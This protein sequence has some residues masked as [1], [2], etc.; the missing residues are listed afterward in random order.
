VDWNQALAL[1]TLQSAANTYPELTLDDLTQLLDA[2]AAY[3]TWTAGT[4]YAYG[5]TV[6]PTVSNGHV[7]R[8]IAGGIS[9]TTEPFWPLYSSSDDRLGLTRPYYVGTLPNAEVTDG[10]VTFVEAGPI[11]EQY[12]VALATWKAWHI[13]ASRASADMT[14]QVGQLRVQ[15]SQVHEHCV[16]TALRYMPARIA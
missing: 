12:D 10:T 3:S 15:A 11:T 8:V 13:K 14:F 9:G 1:L 2:T 6:A 7:Y 5:A 16:A 4:P